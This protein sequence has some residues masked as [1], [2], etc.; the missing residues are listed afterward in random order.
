MRK[1]LTYLFFVF[2]ILSCD[3]QGGQNSDV[4]SDEMKNST[5]LKGYDKMTYVDSTSEGMTYTINQ[6]QFLSKATLHSQVSNKENYHIHNFK[7]VNGNM[8]GCYIGRHP[9]DPWPINFYRDD[10]NILFEVADSIEAKEYYLDTFDVN[11]DRSFFNNE[12]NNTSKSFETVKMLMEVIKMNNK[13]L[14]I[15]K[16]FTNSEGPIDIIVDFSEDSIHSKIHFLSDSRIWIDNEKLI[17]IA[18][19]L[20]VKK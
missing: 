6:F 2:V 3:H 13:V 12:S 14:W 15:R 17:S 20:A 5:T 19:S 16:P 7:T 4:K 9:K 8:F 11:I 18:K 10:N 1:Y